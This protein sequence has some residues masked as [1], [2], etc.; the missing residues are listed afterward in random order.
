VFDGQKLPQ[1]K[2]GITV[3][4]LVSVL[5]T[6]NIHLLTIIVGAGM[7]QVK[8][9]WFGRRA[10]PLTDFDM[11]DEASKGPTGSIALLLRGR[12]EFPAIAGACLIVLLLAVGPFVQQIIA[13]EDRPVSQSTASIPTAQNYSTTADVDQNSL[14]V[15]MKATVLNG[16]LTTPVV[17]YQDLPNCATGNCTWANYQS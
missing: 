9:I 17:E 1:W 7:G 10:R 8:W 11:I 14:S 6:I 12:G 13:F 2:F 4:T 16:A 15:D 5:A 3:N